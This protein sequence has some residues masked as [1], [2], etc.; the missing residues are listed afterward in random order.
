MLITDF[1]K[2]SPIDLHEI[3]GFGVGAVEVAEFVFLSQQQA[4]VSE[5]RA[6]CD[7]GVA[8]LASF[9]HNVHLAADNEIYILRNFVCFDNNRVGFVVEKLDIAQLFTVSTKLL[10]GGCHEDLPPE[11]VTASL[12][13]RSKLLIKVFE[14]QVQNKVLV[15]W[16]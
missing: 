2:L 15:A 8:V 3:R 10:K 14:N 9:V 16:L 4:D 1:Q 5:I 12:K 13:R 6:L 11:S 7:G